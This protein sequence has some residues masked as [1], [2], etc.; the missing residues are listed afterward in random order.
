VGL[1]RL[2]ALRRRRGDAL[3][4]YERLK[5]VL[6]QEFGTQ[7]DA[8]SRDLREEIAGRR[9]PPPNGQPRVVSEPA[10][11]SEGQREDTGES[12][13]HN[14]PVQRTSFVG[15][16]RE[17]LEVKRALAIPDSSRSPGQEGLARRG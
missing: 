3:R 7:P 15:R 17:M 11:P 16:E 8:A 5:E 1:M 14:L 10:S 9:F 13:K 4:Q 12:S 6:F 2:Y